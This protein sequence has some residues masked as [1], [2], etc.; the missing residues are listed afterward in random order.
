M[1]K[2]I[3]A[4]VFVYAYTDSPFKHEAR[5]YLQLPAKTDALVLAETFGALKRITKN[6]HY[7]EQTLKQ[8]MSAHEIIPV[9]Q[10]EVFAALKITDSSIGDAIHIVCANGAEIVTFDQDFKRRK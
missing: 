7:A 10:S 6:H 1:K 9:T 5:E 8:I 3:D 4:N 2:F